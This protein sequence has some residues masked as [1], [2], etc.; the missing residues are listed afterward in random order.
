MADDDPREQPKRR[1]IWGTG[2]HGQGFTD[3]AGR[4][5]S[6]EDYGATDHGGEPE[7]GRTGT[8]GRNPP[9]HKGDEPVTADRP[10]AD[11]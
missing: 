9:P 2:K 3:P 8:G 5:Y 6:R 7:P 4:A 10:D 11:R 1:G